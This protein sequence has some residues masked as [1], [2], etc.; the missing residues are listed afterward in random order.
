MSRRPIL[1]GNWKMNLLRGE[2]RAF[3][4]A[5]SAEVRAAAPDVDVLLFPPAVL[6]D[7][8]VAGVGDAAIGVGGQDVHPSPSGA[9]TG[10]VSAPQLRDA[11]CGWALVGH[12]ERRQDHGE[13]DRAVGRKAQAACEHGLRPM[14]CLGETGDERRAGGTFDVLERQLEA[15]LG[16]A[17]RDGCEFAVA[18]EPVWAIGTGLTATP[19][20]AQEAHAHLRSALGRR[21]GEE[22]AGGVRLL[23]GGSAKPGNVAELFAQPDEES[24]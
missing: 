13:D 15:S 21:L 20:L 4:S 2:A 3:C 11:G 6:I 17:I 10:D 14:I 1:A 12:S 22:R 8:V 7:T 23:Y 5:L 18:Y 19:E 9:H 24:V 16:D